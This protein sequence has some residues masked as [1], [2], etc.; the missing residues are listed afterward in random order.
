[1]SV[2]YDHRN[3]PTLSNRTDFAS[4]RDSFYILIN[5]N[6]FAIK[7]VVALRQEAEGLLRIALF[8]K[9]LRLI[10]TKDGRDITLE[11][12]RQEL[13]FELR[14]RRRRSVVPVFISTMWFLFSL[15]ISI[16]SSFARVG[17]HTTAHDLAIGLLLAWLPILIMCSIVDRNP[18]AA[19]DVRSR[20][21]VLVDMVAKALQ[22]KDVRD[23][24]IE[25]IRRD[26]GSDSPRFRELVDR[27]ERIAATAHHLEQ[28][29]FQ[30]FAGQGRV[31]WHYGAAQPIL[32]DIE[33]S[34]IAIQGREWLRNEPEARLEL[35]LGSSDRGL[36]SFDFRQLWHIASG[37]VIVGG[38][39]LGAW[40]LSYYT[41]TVGL[42]CTYLSEM[43]LCCN[44]SLLTALQADQEATAYI[45]C[46]ALCF[47][48]LSILSGGSRHSSP[49]NSA[50]GITKWRRTQV[51]S[52]EV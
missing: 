14:S 32:T 52:D 24:Y 46:S 30:D 13:A 39:A 38:T 27:V 3:L 22:E 4:M 10:K 8:S 28:D 1:M 2:R 40:V 47:F 26:I 23:H 45:Y 50:Y 19:E 25:A 41:P 48:S 49:K 43:Y 17:D 42:G 5:M 29:F 33:T 37:V 6:M 51:K 12:E 18:V 31:R 36:I 44:V 34:Y 7:P 15:A 11:K 35:V 20:L 16:E 21:N 9:D